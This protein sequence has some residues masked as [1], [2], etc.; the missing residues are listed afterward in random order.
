MCAPDARLMTASLALNDTPVGYAPEVGPPVYI[1]LAYNHLEDQ[2]ATPNFMNVGPKWTLNVLSYVEDDPTTAGATV[3]RYV[4]GGGFVDYATEAGTFN[5]STGAW[6]QEIQGQ[7]VLKRIPASGTVT[8]Y[9]W[10]AP[11]GSKQTF[12]KLDG[13]STYPRDVFLTSIADPAGNALTLN[14]DATYLRVNSVTDATGR[15]TTLSYGLGGHPLLVSAITDPFSRSA[16]LC[17]C[18]E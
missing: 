18:R 14:Y 16:T 1:R 17:G 6:G 15:T 9:E 4:A 11:D 3:K 12:S 10:T 2:P 13:A 8:S 5:T 7:G